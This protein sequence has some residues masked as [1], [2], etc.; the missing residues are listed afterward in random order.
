MIEFN[1][2]I[3]KNTII[4]LKPIENEVGALN[5]LNIRFEEISQDYIYKTSEGIIV[6]EFPRELTEEGINLDLKALMSLNGALANTIST[7][8]FNIRKSLNQGEMSLNIKSS[9][10]SE[11][12]LKLN[13]T[14]Y[15]FREK[16]KG[17]NKI[18]LSVMINDSDFGIYE[19]IMIPFT[20][21]D[22]QIIFSII[23]DIVSKYNRSRSLFINGERL[24]Y[25]ELEIIE[26]V[27]VPIVKIDNSIVIDNI[28]L[29]GQEILNL[30][31]VVDKLI[32]GLH[33]EEDL[34]TINTFYRQIKIVNENGIA[35]LILRKMNERHEEVPIKTSEGEDCKLKIQFSTD[36]LSIL[37]SFLSIQVLRHAD[38][39]FEYDDSVE[40]IGS[41][42]PFIN[43]KGMKYHISLRESFLGLSITE[44]QK[45]GKKNISLV[46]K[47]KEGAYQLETEEGLVSSIFSKNGEIKSI[48]NEF[49]INL[50][51]Q[52]PKLIKAFSL[53]YNK[54]YLTKDK[55]FNLI[56][57]FIITNDNT[58]KY[59]YQFSILSNKENKASAVLNIEK[60]KIKDREE[61]FISSYRQPLFERYVFQLLL[62]L[63]A[64]SDFIENISYLEEVNKK[65]IIS[66][67]Y[68]SMKNVIKL[69]KNEKLDYGIKKI[70]NLTF[71]GIFSN[72]NKMFNE[73]SPQ[74]QF[75]LNQSSQS[76]IFRGYWIPFVGETIAIGPDRF[77]TDTFGEINLEKNSE[78]EGIDWAI[79]LFF[80]TSS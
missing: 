29:H 30:M 49:N 50:R 48:L 9:L 77:L 8:L 17:R 28:W 76:K 61:T 43:I 39:D 5:G 2:I 73:L 23:K 35:Y 11:K 24:A 33:I 51:D 60:F 59:K 47:V 13:I 72:N 4:H 27:N 63:L 36:F 58:G 41:Q 44:S 80:G 70:D 7:Y 3:L 15:F 65:D 42:D 40:I 52:W 62:M 69:T 46:G 45:D 54:L 71:W 55:D 1:N 12:F 34:D 6:Q 22:V 16:T 21:K 75:L 25:D 32:H 20:K 66:Y 68:K 53:A 14:K 79:K 19:S 56:K 64:S 37:Y 74:D 31:Y 57:F 38:I 78:I 26:E 10:E 67:R 18:E